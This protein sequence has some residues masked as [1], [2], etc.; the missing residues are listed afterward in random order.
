MVVSGI[1]VVITTIIL[2]NYSQF[3]GA[4]TLRN[5]AYE[6]A[7]SV[8]EAQTYGISVRRFGDDVFSAGYGVHVRESSPTTYILYADTIENGYYDAGE[9]VESFSLGSGFIIQDIC[10]VPAGSETENCNVERLD[11]I[12]ERPEPDAKIR[13]NDGTLLN[14]RARIVL[15]APRGELIS[16]LVEATGQI[17]VGNIVKP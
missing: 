9:T 6:V 10:I 12:F 15:Q 13:F 14:Q 4:V 1:L 7:L 17:S 8:R 11:V 2:A 16:I 5:L 3:G